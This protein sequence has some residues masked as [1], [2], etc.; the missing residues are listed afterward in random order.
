MIGVRLIQKGQ[1]SGIFKLRVDFDTTDARGDLFFLRLRWRGFGLWGGA[2][3]RVRAGTLLGRAATNS[4][5]ARTGASALRIAARTNARGPTRAG[6][7]LALRFRWTRCRAARSAWTAWATGAAG[8]TRTA[9][10]AGAAG[11]WAAAWPTGAAWSTWAAGSAR[12]TGSTRSARAAWP[13]RSAGA[14]A[15]ARPA[16]AARPTRSTRAAWAGASGASARWAALLF[17]LFFL[18]EIAH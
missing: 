4:L 18:S 11:A 17:V 1:V 10:A 5:G 13:T 6:F 2:E 7:T 3:G 12:S 8:A 9:G 14:R 16:R 15:A